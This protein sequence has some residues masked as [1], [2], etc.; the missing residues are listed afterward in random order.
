MVQFLGFV[1]GSVVGTERGAGDCS[2]FVFAFEMMRSMG[3]S[4]GVFRVCWGYRERCGSLW[5]QTWHVVDAS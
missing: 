1:E 4:M 2:V 3:R 5:P